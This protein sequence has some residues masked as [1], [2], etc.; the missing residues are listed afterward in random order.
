MIFG[1]TICCI[2]MV[3]ML[4]IYIIVHDNKKSFVCAFCLLIK[5]DCEVLIMNITSNNYEQEVTKSDKP[6]LLDFW[7]EGCMPCK[8]F[9]S[10]LEQF[11]KE[12]PEIKVGKINVNDEM[13][14]AQKYNIEFVPTIVFIK[15]GQVVSTEVGFR[16]KGQLEDLC[17]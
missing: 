12:H 7:S 16:E 14:L 6:V 17:K 15:D 9:A 4:Y 5:K 3:S 2:K 11:E 8:M 1:N 10:V 13:S